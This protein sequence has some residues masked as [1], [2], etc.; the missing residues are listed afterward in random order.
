MQDIQRTWCSS[1]MTATADRSTRKLWKAAGDA[2]CLLVPPTL[3]A[4]PQVL[5]EVVATSF[6]KSSLK[7]IRRPPSSETDPSAKSLRKR[8]LATVPS[9]TW[10]LLP[11]RWHSTLPRPW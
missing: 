10:Q 7:G 5:E 3:K 4:S 9:A 8:T 11:K 6:V 2:K 1:K